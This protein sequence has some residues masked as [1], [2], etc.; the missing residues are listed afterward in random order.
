MDRGI[1]AIICEILYWPLL[2]RLLMVGGAN[3]SEL[4][5]CGTML[6]LVVASISFLRAL[7]LDIQVLPSQTKDCCICLTLVVNAV[8]CVDSRV[9]MMS[10][11]AY[12]RPSLNYQI[13]GMRNHFIVRDT[14]AVYTKAP[15]NRKKCF[16]YASGTWLSDSDADPTLV[17]RTC[18]PHY[19]IL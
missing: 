1:L 14:P 2:E 18:G 11:L 16:V 8:A 17:R 7:N 9:Y 5:Y 4:R 19:V 3:A 15:R 13:R 10:W 6:S 12:V